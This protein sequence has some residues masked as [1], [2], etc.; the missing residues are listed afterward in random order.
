M[1][2]LSCL[3]SVAQCILAHV[4]LPE[5]SKLLQTA[6]N[7]VQHCAE[8]PEKKAPETGTKGQFR[9]VAQR[10]PSLSARALLCPQS[11]ASDNRVWSYPHVVLHLP[12]AAFPRWL[13]TGRR[14]VVQ[15]R[16]QERAAET[17]ICRSL[18]SDIL[19]A[20][21]TVL[22]FCA[23]PRVNFG[24]LSFLAGP[25]VAVVAGLRLCFLAYEY[26][27]SS[28]LT[29]GHLILGR[30]QAHSAVRL[31]TGQLVRSLF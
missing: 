20:A 11:W 15:L 5:A 6:S 22:I 27:L 29:P 28:Q 14:G 30:A 17:A 9:S 18:G 26:E 19:S 24:C 7:L 25:A 2:P 16:A 12:I 23:L 10:F 4:G 21:E 13:F 1:C 3:A 8:S 31:H